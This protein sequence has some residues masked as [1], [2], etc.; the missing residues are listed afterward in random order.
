VT[1]IGKDGG[2]V[3]DA[4]V[5]LVA[6]PGGAVADIFGNV[7]GWEG[8]TVIDAT[9]LVGAQPP[10][11]FAS[12]AE[13]IKSKTNGTTAKSFNLNFARLY[14]EIDKARTRPSNIWSGDEEARPVVEQLTRDAGYEPVYAGGMEKTSVQEQGIALIFA[15]SQASGPFVYRI[16][17]PAEL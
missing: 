8:K 12:N 6:V 5:V 11:G 13:Y 15:V 3:S 14:D 9:N 16:A 7:T 17:P 4:D 10:D 1:R 2:D